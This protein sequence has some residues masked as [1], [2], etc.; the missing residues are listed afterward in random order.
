LHLSFS[1]RQILLLLNA[2]GLKAL[3]LGVRANVK[4][5]V[6]AKKNT[7]IATKTTIN[8]RYESNEVMVG[9]TEV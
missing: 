4:F 9:V 8:V 1:L 2:L 5:A 7:H 3:T 6:G